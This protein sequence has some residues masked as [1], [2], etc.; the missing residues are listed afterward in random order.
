MQT[1]RIVTKVDATGHLTG[2][3]LLPPGRTVEVIMLVMD[4][5]L[6]FVRRKPPKKLQ[7][8]VRITGEVLTTASSSDWGIP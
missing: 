2:L 6:S 4:Q 5:P 7:G 3:P 8:K 1:Q